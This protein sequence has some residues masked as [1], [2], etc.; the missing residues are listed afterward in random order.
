MNNPNT[1]TCLQAAIVSPG[2]QG[3][4][5]SLLVEA[6]PTIGDNPPGAAGRQMYMVLDGHNRFAALRALQVSGVLSS[7]Y[8]V[9][10]ITLK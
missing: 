1:D 7:D 3:K 4:R 8:V 10:V 6:I 5:S 9:P 2:Y